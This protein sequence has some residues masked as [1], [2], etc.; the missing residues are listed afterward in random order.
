MNDIYNILSKH[1]LNET[2]KQEKLKI[3]EFKKTN[4]TEYQILKK[5]WE[6]GALEVKDF[7]SGKAW[8]TI[9]EKVKRKNNKLGKVVPLNVR[10]GQIAAVAVILIIGAFASYY[11]IHSSKSL[12]SINTAQIVQTEASVFERGKI[13]TLVDGSEVWLN[14]GA[15]ITYPKQ[16]TGTVR[17]V[18][19][20]GE[21]FFKV[22]KNRRKPF[23][24]KTANSIIK[25]IGTSFNV[26]S[27]KEKTEV[28]VATGTVKVTNTA[29][30]KNVIIPKGFS[31][32]V[33]GN[34]VEKFETANPNFQA[35]RTG[36]FEFKNAEITKVV[37]ELNR[38]YK[39]QLYI[40]NAGEN[41]CQF[42]ANFDQTKIED[43]V[44]IIE[45]AC[46]INLTIE[47]KK[48]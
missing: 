43:V 21:A 13:V 34:I 41:N 48:P 15:T 6:N 25:V 1:F 30:H 39:R 42:T 2:T 16:F 23:I 19:L 14:R 32:K 44:E 26:C 22:A 31:A 8:N 46:D 5:L 29:T 33:S 4:K 40:N 37:D 36:K 28:T 27:V 7:D 12:E 9:Q 38:Y 10:F 35:W 45:L 3:A 47:N 17:N 18:E 20:K 24:I 11:F